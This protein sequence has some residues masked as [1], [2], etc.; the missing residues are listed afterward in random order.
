MKK[1]SGFTLIELM[2]TVAIIGILLRIAVPAY[3]TYMSSGKIAEGT[4]TLVTTRAALEQYYADNR[5][6]DNYTG[7]ICAAAPNNTTKYFSYACTLATNSYTIT[8]TGLSTSGVPN[9]ALTIDQADVRT[10]TIPAALNG[11]GSAIT[12][13][14]CW[15]KS[16]KSTGC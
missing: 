15:A 14:T 13:S 5:R 11:T 6:Y 9:L 4:S 7:G 2:I 12:L 1:M 8:A 10:T 3:S 16:I